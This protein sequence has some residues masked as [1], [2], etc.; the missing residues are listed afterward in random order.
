MIEPTWMTEFR[1][2]KQQHDEERRRI[3]D[4]KI[5]SQTI[6]LCNVNTALVSFSLPNGIR[7]YL[8][9]HAVRLGLCGFVRR[10]HHTFVEIRIDGTLRQL[11][12]YRAILEGLV[13]QTVCKSLEIKH[14][15]ELI[16]G[17]VYHS[18]EIESNT[19]KRC[20][21]NPNSDGGQWE[22]QSSSVSSDQEYFG[23]SF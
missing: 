22:K 16:S 6:F 21:K 7:E 4:E 8:R 19:H 13:R 15:V 18:F 17:H 23:G 12:G 20:A 14:A 11:S 10:S 9:S 2:W 5:Y 3:E 1:L